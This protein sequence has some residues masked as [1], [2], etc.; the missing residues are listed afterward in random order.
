MVL[1][2]FLTAIIQRVESPLPNIEGSSPKHQDQTI[3]N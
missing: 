1:K 2:L 3:N